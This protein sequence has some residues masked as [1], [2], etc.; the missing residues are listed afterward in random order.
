MEICVNVNKKTNKA[1][2]AFYEELHDESSLVNDI[3]TKLLEN[4][5]NVK[6]LVETKLP[7]GFIINVVNPDFK[8]TA[9]ETCHIDIEFDVIKL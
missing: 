2:V 8:I 6:K 4:D 5:F 3:T 1:V 7:I 9:K